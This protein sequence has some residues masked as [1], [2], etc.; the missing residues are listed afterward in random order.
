MKQA[1][2]NLLD[3]RVPGSVVRLLLGRLLRHKAKVA[4]FTNPLHLPYV[5]VNR[6]GSNYL[7]PGDSY[8]ARRSPASEVVSFDGGAYEPEVSYLMKA[9]IKPDHIVLDIGANVGLHTVAMARLASRGHVYAFEPVAEMA[10]R[11]SV[12][13]S[14][15][16]IENVTIVRCGLGEENGEL[17]MNVNVGGDGLEGTSSFLETSHVVNRP[18]DFTVRHVPVRRLDDVLASF[19]LEGRRIGFIKI[20]TEGFEP[21][22]LAGGMDAIRRHRPAMVIEAHSTRLQRFGKSFGWYQETFPDHHVLMV[23]AST[24]ANPYLRIEP[25]TEEPPE[26]CVNLLLLPRTA[27]HIPS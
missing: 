23:L 8:L 9:L 3:H 17:E 7:A 14:L 6:S 12:N 15:N 16:A 27:T 4:G 20:D 25:L 2:L 10:E 11:N 1:I 18:T 26:V 21:F 24:P 13:C 19:D 22:V 5:V